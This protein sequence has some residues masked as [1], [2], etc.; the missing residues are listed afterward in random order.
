[1][2]SSQVSGSAFPLTRKWQQGYS[3]EDVD[4]F[5]ATVSGKTAEDVR[6]AT[7]PVTRFKPGYRMASVDDSLDE[8]VARLDPGSG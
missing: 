7:F 6:R 4:A 3:I 2:S 1:M 8:W 5:M